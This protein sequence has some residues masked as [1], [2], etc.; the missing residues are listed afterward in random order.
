MDLVYLL[1]LLQ[2]S[3]WKYRRIFLFVHLAKEICSYFFFFY[4]D[5][6]VMESTPA[7]EALLLIPVLRNT[8]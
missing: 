6:V 8:A 1:L 2:C 7:L 4:S 3:E 5:G